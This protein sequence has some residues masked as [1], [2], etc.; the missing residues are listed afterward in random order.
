M[1]LFGSDVA[2]RIVARVIHEDVRE[3]DDDDVASMSIRAPE[4]LRATIDALAKMAGTSRNTMAV[5]LLRAGVSDVLNQLPPEIAQELVDEVGG[6][7]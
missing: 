3:D 6:F 5:D 7:L 1:G 2:G 4:T